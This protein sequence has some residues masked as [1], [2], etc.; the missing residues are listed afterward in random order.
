MVRE[1]DAHPGKFLRVE[2]IYE[3]ISS[4]KRLFSILGN[5]PSQGLQF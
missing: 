3:D 4:K 5:L 2:I 1:L